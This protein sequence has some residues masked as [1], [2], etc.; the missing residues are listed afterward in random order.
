[1]IS[2]SV[3]AVVNDGGCAADTCAAGSSFVVA[4]AAKAVTA[5]TPTA[6]LNSKVRRG[7]RMIPSLDALIRFF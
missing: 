2:G 4:Q 5:M 6:A 1:M 3:G 7:A